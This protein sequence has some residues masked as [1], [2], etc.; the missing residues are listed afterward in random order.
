Y[1]ILKL[2]HQSVEVLKGKKQVWMFTTHVPKQMPEDYQAD[3]FEQLRQLRKQEADARKVPP[4]IL[5]SDA[6]LK[7]LSRYFPETKEE[8]LNIK[9]IGEKK[10]EQFG[11]LFLNVILKWRQ[12]NPDTEKRVPVSSQ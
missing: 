9:G 7:E 10:Y 3:L 4:Y 1:P 12:D 8:M 2:N 6:T 5:F 11:E